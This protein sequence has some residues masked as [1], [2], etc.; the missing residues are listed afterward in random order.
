[1]EG[2]K[3]LVT[4]PRQSVMAPN[5]NSSKNA[6]DSSEL[7]LAAQQS[8]ASL[9]DRPKMLP[10]PNQL[11]GRRRQS[12]ESGSSPVINLTNVAA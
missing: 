6:V 7:P 1:M 9:H 5:L 4:A 12:A 2:K 11:N 10:D 3:L 8:Q